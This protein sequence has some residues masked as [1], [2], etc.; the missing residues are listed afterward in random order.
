[1]SNAKTKMAEG[2]GQ[3]K[4]AQ[5]KGRKMYGPGCCGH[6]IPDSKIM[7]HKAFVRK[8]N[9]NRLANWKGEWPGLHPDAQQIAGA[10]AYLTNESAE[11]TQAA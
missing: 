10:H 11:F 5:K 8:M 4:Y 9:P 2:S 3:S 7:A 6:S 1:M